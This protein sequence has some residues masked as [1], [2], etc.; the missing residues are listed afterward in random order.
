MPTCAALARM[1]GTAASFAAPAAVKATTTTPA[2]MA[3]AFMTAPD[4]QQMKGWRSVTSG[5]CCDGAGAATGSSPGLR[6]PADRE[7]VERFLDRGLVGGLGQ[8]NDDDDRA[9]LDHSSNTGDTGHAAQ[10]LGDGL[11]RG[12]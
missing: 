7:P 1:A 10:R 2:R 9:V 3:I 4:D 11:P 12:H 8:R 5:S 6:A